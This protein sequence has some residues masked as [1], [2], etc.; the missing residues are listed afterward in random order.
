MSLR[1]KMSFESHRR[2]ER[3]VVYHIRS[4]VR[5]NSLPRWVGLFPGRREPGTPSGVPASSRRLSEAIPPETGRTHERVRARSV[6][7]VRTRPRVGVGRRYRRGLGYCP[8]AV[9]I[10]ASAGMT[11]VEGD[12]AS[13][14][15]MT[16]VGVSDP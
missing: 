9:W 16:G 7:R 15:G 8:G 12:A 11:G 6:T 3:P 5:H 1:A 14:R 2:H 4:S 13:S 10:P